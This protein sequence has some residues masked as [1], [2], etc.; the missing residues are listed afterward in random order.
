MPLIPEDSLSVSGSAYT[1][2]LLPSKH[3]EISMWYA[4]SL[5]SIFKRS[6]YGLLTLQRG[7]I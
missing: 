3:T 2:K 6:A 5:N 7:G 4:R 1:A